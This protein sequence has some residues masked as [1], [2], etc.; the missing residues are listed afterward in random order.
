MKVRIILVACMALAIPTS[1]QVGEQASSVPLAPKASPPLADEPFVITMTEIPGNPQ[2]AFIGGVSAA[3]LDGPGSY[4]SGI[5]A[6]IVNGGIFLET[7]VGYIWGVRGGTQVFEIPASVYF[8]DNTQFPLAVAENGTTVGWNLFS[9]TASSYPFRWT[10]A[11]GYQLLPTPGS[12]WNG[13]AV[14]LSSDGEVIAGWLGL[15]LAGTSQAVLWD[16][17]VLQFIGTEPYSQARDISSDGRVIVGESGAGFAAPHATRWIGGLESA[18]ELASG[19]TASAAHVVSDDGKITYGWAEIGSQRHLVRWS[20]TG[21]SLLL[22]PPKGLSVVEINATN[23]TGSCVV[24]ALDRLPVP[25]GLL[26]NDQVPFVW[27]QGKGFTLITEAG[28][29][30]DYDYSAALDVTDDG[31]TVVG[32]LRAISTFNGFPPRKAFMWNALSGMNTLDDLMEEQGLPDRGLYR[33]LA[34]SGDGTRLVATGVVQSTPKVT[35][36]VLLEFSK[37]PFAVE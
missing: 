28:L 5:T 8:N 18:L 22:T 10:R 26:V 31:D 16:R 37:K 4:A 3:N 34:I 29:P 33:V 36:S 1:A 30:S 21:Q 32:E 12:Q 19:E 15:G 14:S 35:P 25:V 24:G 7:R 13:R 20:E 9:D 6:W 17:G 11:K 23:R 2:T 27:R